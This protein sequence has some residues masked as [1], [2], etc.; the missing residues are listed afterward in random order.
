[1]DPSPDRPELSILIPA[2]NEEAAI[3]SV[4][5]KV[6]ERHPRASQFE[7]HSPG[8]VTP[9]HLDDH[10][11]LRG[12]NRPGSLSIILPWETANSPAEAPLVAAGEG[13]DLQA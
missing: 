7:V 5:L 8:I 4:L 3:H 12:D 13:T 6:R 9:F 1:M 10:R 11:T 2:F